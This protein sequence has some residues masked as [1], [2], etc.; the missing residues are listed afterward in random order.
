MSCERL[1]HDPIDHVAAITASH[2]DRPCRIHIIKLRLDI[3]EAS[4]QIQERAS[5]P[6]ALDGV[7]EVL[8]E[9]RG[10]GRVRQND[11]VALLCEDG[12]VPARAP[13]VEEGGRGPAVDPVEEGVFLV[14]GEGRGFDDEG[15][16]VVGASAGEFDVGDL[17]G[18][19][20]GM[21]GAVVGVAGDFA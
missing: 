8:P 15:V 1:A 3:V 12:R 9:A 16:E 20:G 6:I 13:L 4:D 2:R 19:V 7:D 10:A 17:R 5:A 14:R 11:D 21:G 18:G